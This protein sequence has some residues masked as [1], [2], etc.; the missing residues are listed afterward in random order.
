MDDLDILLKNVL[1]DEVKYSEQDIDKNFFKLKNQLISQNSK[2]RFNTFSYINIKKFSV[3]L[4]CCLICTTA[5]LISSSSTVRAAA[6]DAIDSIKYIFVAEYS[7]E[8][9][10]V[11]QKPTSEVK[12]VP[13]VWTTTFKSDVEVGELVGYKIVFPK[14]LDKV[15]ILDNRALGVTLDKELPYD[16]IPKLQ[17]QMIQACNNEEEFTKL[18]K[19]SPYRSFSGN[20]KKDDL[21]IF[22]NS[23][24]I[25]GDFSS[26]SENE[27]VKIGDIKGFW[28]KYKYPNYPVIDKDGIGQSDFSV[29]PNIKYDYNLNWVNNNIQ[30]S[31]SATLEGSLS[32]EEAIKI[33]TEFQAAQK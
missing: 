7:G 23:S 6:L 13:S 2:N 12:F 15:F 1:S 9:V 30:Y 19:Y 24:P 17:Q 27:E 14:T 11:V 18:S 22:I 3:I 4:V 32:K 31:L 25:L 29:K 21:T 20:Y 8:D 10:K 5:I 28:C 33:A 26:N 16:F